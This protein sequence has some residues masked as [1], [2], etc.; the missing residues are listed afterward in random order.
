MAQLNNIVVNYPGTDTVFTGSAEETVKWLEA[1]PSLTPRW[2][3]VGETSDILTEPEFL[4]LAS[5]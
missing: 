1:N 4:D 3:Y 2:V 5:D